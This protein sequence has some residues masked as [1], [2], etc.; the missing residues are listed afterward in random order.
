MSSFKELRPLARV[1]VLVP[2]S[3]P[4]VEPEL[5]HLVGND[6]A[7]YAARF[8]YTPEL[9]LQA[10]IERYPDVFL[11]C[12]KAFGAIELNAYLAAMT[13]A[14]YGLLKAGDDA[15]C[16]KLSTATGTVS[17]TACRAIRLS[18]E[19]LGARK[20]ALIS[21]YPEWLTKRA[22]G[23]WEDCGFDLTQVIMM[24]EEFRAYEMESDE[25][26]ETLAKIDGDACDAVVM[27]GT[28]M[29]TI[30]AILELRESI[31][32]TLLSSNLCAAWWIMQTVGSKGSDALAAACPA[33]QEC[34]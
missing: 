6:I 19:A 5:H 16:E 9:D 4:T 31:K 18:L 23:Y 29:L 21:P 14:S 1:G 10:R 24:S 11:A 25:V 27:T 28:G 20:V 30:P 34:L 8:P 32:P 12:A 3:N 33:L 22:A 7:L 13:G 2:T 17:T 15:L 26:A